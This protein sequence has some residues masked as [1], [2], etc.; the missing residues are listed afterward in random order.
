MFH[1]DLIVLFH[2]YN[3]INYLSYL[4]CIFYQ[5][6]QL[7]SMDYIIVKGLI[8]YINLFKIR[9]FTNSYKIMS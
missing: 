7:N 1:L 6:I 9:R 5:T 8:K 3:Q 2:Y 4:V